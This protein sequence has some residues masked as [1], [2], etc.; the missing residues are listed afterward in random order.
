MGINKIAAYSSKSTIME[1]FEEEH[2]KVDVETYLVKACAECISTV[3]SHIMKLNLFHK[4]KCSLL[5]IVHL[6]YK[7]QPELNMYMYTALC[8]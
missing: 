8:I 2:G 1:V 7:C 3:N 4:T 5:Q 6:N